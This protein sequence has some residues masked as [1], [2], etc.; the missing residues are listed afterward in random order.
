MPGTRN[1]AVPQISEAILTHY[2]GVGGL[3]PCEQPC[4][5][6]TPDF[7]RRILELDPPVQH[8]KKVLQPPLI[9]RLSW[10]E[11]VGAAPRS[12][13]VEP[14]PR[15]GSAHLPARRRPQQGPVAP[16]RH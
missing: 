7:I 6:S 4:R 1:H 15:V 16:T 12:N 14:A 10:H 11:P 9:I 5:H 3:Q 13:L 2:P 8:L